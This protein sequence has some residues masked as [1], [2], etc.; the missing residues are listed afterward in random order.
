M[1]SEPL[2]DPE[3]R[4]AG[5][6]R[7]GR[8][9]EIRQC[10]G[11][12]G[13]RGRECPGPQAAGQDALRK[14]EP[15]RRG[16]RTSQRADVP[17]VFGAEGQG[18]NAELDRVPRPRHPGRQHVPCPGC[19]GNRHD[20]LRSAE[21]HRDRG[22]DPGRCGG[23]DRE[24]DQ[25]APGARTDRRHPEGNRRQ[26]GGHAQG[27]PEDRRGA[28]DGRGGPQ[29]ARRAGGAGGGPPA[30]PDGAEEVHRPFHPPEEPH[31]PPRPRGGL[32]RGGRQ[33]SRATS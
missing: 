31:R 32:G 33:A 4:A 6:R 13:D 2:S 8:H 12:C 28:E 16:P 27:I 25:P 30:L 19:E 1:L 24:P 29:R 3:N 23:G 20:R 14:T 26:G 9:G 10:R 22:H 17:D 7:G 11:H 15:D 18:R 21:L 5:I